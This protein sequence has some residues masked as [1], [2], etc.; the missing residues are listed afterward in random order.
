MLELFCIEIA[1]KLPVDAVQEIQVKLGGHILGVVIGPFQQLNV[2][3]QIEAD[4]EI[5]SI[6]QGVPGNYHTDLFLPLLDRVAQV[7]GRPYEADSDEGVSYR[8]LADH[9]RA[10]AFLLADGVFP[11]NEGRG[12]VLRRVLRRAVRHA[13]ILGRREPTLVD[14]VERVTEEMGEAYPDLLVRR[15]HLLKTTR[16]EEERFLSTIE[17]GM[18][19]FDELAPRAPLNAYSRVRPAPLAI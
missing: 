6:L 10:V 2:L 4:Q 14:V 7:V 12:Y 16:A 8:V 13:W 1:T 3:L 11:S 17:G 9:A 15:E 19:R 5:V 18:S